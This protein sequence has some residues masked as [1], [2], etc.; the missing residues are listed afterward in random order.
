MKTPALCI[1]SPKETEGSSRRIQYGN[2][3]RGEIN[4]DPEKEMHGIAEK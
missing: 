4:N 3:I 1:N 2:E